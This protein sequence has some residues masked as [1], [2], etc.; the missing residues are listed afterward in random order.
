MFVISI[1]AFDAASSARGPFVPD[2]GIGAQ[3]LLQL[4]VTSRHD[5][6]HSFA[7]GHN[8]RDAMGWY[9]NRI[10]PVLIDRGMRN[11]V[12][13][14]HRATTVPL[15]S[16][17][18]LEV[19]LGSGLNIP[20][21]T[22]KVDRLYGLEPSQDL[23]G[24]AALLADAAP[25]PVELLAAPAED[26]PLENDSVDTVF[27]SWTLCS[28]PSLKVALKEMRRVLRPGGRF[29]FIEHGRA[30]DANVAKWQDRIAPVLRVLAGCSPNKKMDD[31]IVEAGFE[32]TQMEK[33]YLKGPK[34]ISYH[35]IGQARSPLA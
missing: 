11:E 34:F 12:M 20:Y 27:S 13:A 1:A 21:Y 32:V 29:I 9:E 26:I 14:E 18:V 10:L 16:Q 5:G 17:T 19:G 25:F 35:Y 2:T 28:I 15:A 3:G 24:K 7:Q 6:A 30:P 4:R 33:S 23:L 22:N 8:E 31:L